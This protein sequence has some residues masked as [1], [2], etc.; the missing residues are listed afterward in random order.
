MIDH[1]LELLDSSPVPSDLLV[2]LF[3]GQESAAAA[4]AVLVI[5]AVFERC[6]AKY[7][8]RGYR[9]ILIEAGHVG[10]NAMLSC[11]SLGLASLPLGAFLDVRLS[12]LLG[13][14]DGAEMPVYA[15]AL[16]YP[17]RQKTDIGEMWQT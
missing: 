15:I 7:G 11:E 9:Y 1:S 6:L 17:Q 2:E 10:Q 16:G 3:L 5:T 12:N 4:A 14:D 13:V 8:D